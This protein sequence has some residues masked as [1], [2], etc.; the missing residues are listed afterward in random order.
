[1]GCGKPAK[2]SRTLCQACIDKR[3]LVSSAHYRRRKEAGTCI[4]CENPPRDGKVTCKQCWRRIRK[5]KRHIKLGVL[6]AYGGRTCALC[7][8]ADIS[9]LEIDHIG[10]GGT[11]HRRELGK[12]EPAAA[13]GHVFYL[14]LRKNGYPSGYRV[15]CPN[16]NRKT[17][18]D[19]LKAKRKNP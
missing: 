16:C 11:K 18:L 10:G 5:Y 3:S 13:A 6:D 2:E 15:L 7:G 17:H 19:R 8:H 4:Y 14:W 9:V 1:M 12:G